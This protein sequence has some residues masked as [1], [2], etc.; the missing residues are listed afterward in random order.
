MSIVKLDVQNFK[1]EVID[2]QK[3][4]MVDF[5]ADW[6]GPCRMLTPSIESLAGE[7]SEDLKIAKLNVDTAGELAAQFG[8][9]GI[10]TVMMFKNGSVVDHFT[11]ALP[12]QSI[13]QF[14]K[15]NIN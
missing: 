6:C 9:S 7:Y 15:K 3:P 4:V 12:K 14:I 8:V 1:S 13:E 5:Y 2:S 10:P 11:G